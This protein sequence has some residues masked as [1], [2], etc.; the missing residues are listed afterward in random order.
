MRALSMLPFVLL[1]ACGFSGSEGKEAPDGNLPPGCAPGFVNL[2]DAIEPT[3]DFIIAS[4]EIDTDR[5][6]RCQMIA[7]RN[8]PPICLLYFNEIEIMLGGMLMAHGSRPLALVA[9][10]AMRINGTVD[11][12]SKLSRRNQQGAGGNPLALCMSG[13]P[14]QS[15]RGGGGGGAGGSLGTSGG[16]GGNGNLDSSDGVLPVT[17]GGAGAALPALLALRG[18]CNGQDGGVGQSAPGGSGGQ[19]GGAVYLSAASLSIAGSV[20][21][22]GSGGGDS[23]G[24]DGGGGG[25][26]GGV[27]VVESASLAI[28]GTLVAA[29]GGGGKGGN[30]NTGGEAG[31]DAIGVTPAMGGTTGG[32]GGVG[33]NGGT[34]TPGNPGASSNGG[35]GGGGGGTGYILLLSPSHSITGSMMAPPAV[36]RPL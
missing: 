3:S 14:S 36:I 35:G 30:G 29:G 31:D 5:D 13:M 12:S 11:V 15:A 4:T 27:I 33:G 19:G 20:L 16:V 22:G 6:L 2:C 9:K 24:D 17:G 25:G 18:G 10:N 21:A 23:G 8:G 7:P 1:S 28:S 32:S 26:S 34:D